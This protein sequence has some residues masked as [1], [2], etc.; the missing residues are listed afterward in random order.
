MLLP[1]WI[2]RRYIYILFK[3]YLFWREKETLSPMSVH[4]LFQWSMISGEILI[5]NGQISSIIFRKKWHN[6]KGVNR[7]K[8]KQIGKG[9][10]THLEMFFV[11]WSQSIPDET[12]ENP[13]IVTHIVKV[14]SLQLHTPMK[15]QGHSPLLWLNLQVSWF[16]CLAFEETHQQQGTVA[17][18]RNA[19]QQIQGP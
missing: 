1:R 15:F 6:G 2:Y 13:Q 17:V 16:P 14:C 7:V 9:L 12:W 19:W 10:K 8:T 3:V 18:A 11:C 4:I 5:W